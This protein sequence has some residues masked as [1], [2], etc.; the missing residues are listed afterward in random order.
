M[1]YLQQFPDLGWL[2]QQIQSGF[3]TAGGQGWPTVLLH[4]KQP[5][6]RRENIKGTLSLFLT[7]QGQSQLT[8]DGRTLHIGPPAYALTNE[9]STYDLAT[10]RHRDGHL[11]TVFNCHFGTAFLKQAVPYCLAP[12]LQTLLDD[13]FHDQ[14]TPMP[15]FSFHS[16]A[17]TPAFDQAVQQVQHTQIHTASTEAQEMALLQLLEQICLDHFQ[18]QSSSQRLSARRKATKEELFRRV[19]LAADYLHAHCFDAL[20]LEAVAQF[21]CLSKFHLSRAFK[22]VY[23]CAPYQYLQRLRL[24][25][26]LERLPQ[27][28]ASLQVIAE[29]VGLDNASSLSRLVHRATGQYPSAY[30]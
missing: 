15:S 25:A 20:E 13:P 17:R 24:R 12:R 8:H 3:A 30:R 23:G 14:S 21:C 6:T 11:T 26:I 2:R 29:S 5:P 1:R 18:L 27:N 4:V 19:R 10:P 28:N 9:G 7:E 22:A 16:M